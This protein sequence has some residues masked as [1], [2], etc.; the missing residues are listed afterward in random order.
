ME[1]IGIIAEYNPFHSG[2]AYLIKEIREKYPQAT[3]ITLMSGNIVQRGEFAIADKFTRANAAIMNG[4]DLVIQLPIY[5]TLNSADYFANGAIIIAKELGIEKIIFGSETNDLVSLEKSAKLIIKN[6]NK[7]NSLV[8]EK[9]SLPK[10]IKE[11]LGRNFE[12]NDILGI[13]YLKQNLL[14]ETN[15]KFETILRLKNDSFSSASQIRI[16]LIKE[17]ENK[18]NLTK[19]DNLIKMD[20]FFD[21]I[22][23]KI[24]SSN[25]EQ[26]LIKYVKK[27]IAKNKI[28]TWN[29]LIDLCSNGSITK[30]RIRRTI[31]KWFLEIENE[32]ELRVL[33]FN[34]NGQKVL[35]TLKKSGI[36]L[37]NKFNKKMNNDLIIA[38][39]LNLKIDGILDLELNHSSKQ[40]H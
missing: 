2:H 8:K 17:I 28:K 37:S 30:S 21:L 9:G 29:Q 27:I 38:K 16:D 32:E 5:Y 34:D 35:K 39:I 10:A 6:N 40:K 31:L 24:V 3:L 15:I 11:I 12:A 19:I 13:C 14:N 33:A 23:G 20:D 1:K 36:V 25:S 22:I 18:N 26:E 4:I 7:I